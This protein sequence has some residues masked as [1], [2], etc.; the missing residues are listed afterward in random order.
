MS[1][2]TTTPTI[3][4]RKLN[5]AAQLPKRAH[6]GDAGADLTACLDEP[7]T[8]LPGA[9]RVIPTGLAIAIPHGYVGLIHPRSGLAAKHGVTVLNAPGTID[10]AYRG[11]VGVCL[12]NHGLTNVEITP[13]MRI[14]QL[15]VQRVELCAFKE[16]DH[17]D[18][19]ARAAGG[20][21]STGTH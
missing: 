20:W 14:A 18:E 8:L 5:N 6:P 1:T 19:T 10:A 4:V 2:P 9:R 7:V 12:I 13:G 3:E 17:L 11:E 15:V 21:G 16:V